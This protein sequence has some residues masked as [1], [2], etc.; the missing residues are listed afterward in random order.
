MKSTNRKSARDWISLSELRSDFTTALRALKAGR[1]LVLSYRN[2]RI[3]RIVP[4]REPWKQRRGDTIFRLHEIAEP[5]G[6]LKNSA[7]DEM[8]YQR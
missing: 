4:M 7:I 3:G 2:K 8:V 6:P 1:S 5:I